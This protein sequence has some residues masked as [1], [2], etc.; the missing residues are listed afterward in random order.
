MNLKETGCFIQQL[1]KEKGLTQSALALKLG[2]SEKTI[3]KWECGNGFPDTTLMLPLCSELG[4]SAN[5]LLTAKK[6]ESEKEY[7]KSAEDNLVAL[8]GLNE[9]N[10]KLLL[11][12]E[13]PIMI[14]SMVILLGA[15]VVVSYVPLATIWRVLILVSAF[16]L[17]GFGLYFG[18]LIETKA[19][20]Y[21]C[22]NCHHR[23]VPTYKQVLWSMHMGRT[24]HMKCPKC[25][26]RSWQRKKIKDN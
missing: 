2:V 10:T 20:Y 25:G 3:S 26:A 19:G 15:C 17:L 21:E 18:I 11:S 22:K 9:T 8:K 16:L 13:W 6:I 1:R 4:I 24:R 14:L 7:I 5:E 23:H 12:A